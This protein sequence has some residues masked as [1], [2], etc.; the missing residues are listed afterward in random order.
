[1]LS[2]SDNRSHVSA[3]TQVV[4]PKELIAARLPTAPE[5]PPAAVEM[6]SRAAADVQRPRMLS[7]EAVPVR[8]HI[9]ARGAQRAALVCVSQRIVSPRTMRFHTV[10]HRM[11][12]CA[13]GLCRLPH[14]VVRR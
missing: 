3:C 9:H 5:P 12:G 2:C 13:A 7:E 4:S 6:T 10:R 14:A 11:H 8:T 1:M